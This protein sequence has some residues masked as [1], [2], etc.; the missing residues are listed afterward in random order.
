M[1]FDVVSGEGFISQDCNFSDLDFVVLVN[2]ED[3]VFIT[4][5][6]V[7]NFAGN[8]CEEVSFFV[9]MGF[10]FSDV[11]INFIE[12]ERRSDFEV[13]DF[14]E[15]IEADLIVSFDEVGGD[16]WFFDEGVSEDISAI[17][18]VEVD[19]DIVIQ[20]HFIE[21]FDVSTDG[22]QIEFAPSSLFDVV[23]EVF[24]GIT[25]VSFQSDFIDNLSIDIGEEDSLSVSGRSET[26][27]GKQR[28][29]EAAAGSASHEFAPRLETGP[30]QASILFVELFVL[31]VDALS[32]S[33]ASREIFSNSALA[34]GLGT[35]G[36]SVV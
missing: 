6:A 21:A 35:S 12:I 27:S 11:R 18:D 9:V 23:E 36:A 3:D 32:A 26:E 13:D 1:G 31:F 2:F 25:L 5:F 30:G 14:L 8:F 28:D 22:T 10:N 15:V 19:L 29:E 7:T 16:A 33:M 17:F 20:P 34:S 4:V 24:V